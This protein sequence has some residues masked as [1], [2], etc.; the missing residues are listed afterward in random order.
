MQ[1]PRTS[2]RSKRAIKTIGRIARHSLILVRYGFFLSH[3]FNWWFKS[4]LFKGVGL[5]LLVLGLLLIFLGKAG[6]W[7]KRIAKAM[8]LLAVLWVVAVFA[9]DVFGIGRGRPV[10]VY[11]LLDLERFRWS[12]PSL[13]A[14][15][16]TE[17]PVFKSS[18]LLVAC[19]FPRRRCS[20]CR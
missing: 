2:T 12:G 13:N 6:H 7:R 5:G 11:N 4:Q 3:G 8:V 16:H 20:S 17:L 19:G 9:T 1:S 14:G 10:F 18:F 15:K